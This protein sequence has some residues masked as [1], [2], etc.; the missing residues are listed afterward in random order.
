M[1][2]EARFWLRLSVNQEQPVGWRA[3]EVRELQTATL[4]NNLARSP[5]EAKLIGGPPMVEEARLAGRAVINRIGTA[6]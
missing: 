3:E 6:L 5:S 4:V 2:A 1:K